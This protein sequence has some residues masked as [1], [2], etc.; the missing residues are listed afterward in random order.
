MS[1]L[2]FHAQL[3]LDVR[4]ILLVLL[5]EGLSCE[6]L[7]LSLFDLDLLF[8]FH[9]PLQIAV[10][11]QGLEFLFDLGEGESRELDEEVVHDV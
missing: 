11:F 5:A 9:L 8:E 1:D 7:P 3:S 2:L 6:F 4:F 10:V